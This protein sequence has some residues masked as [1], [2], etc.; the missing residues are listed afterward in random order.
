MIAIGLEIIFSP[1]IIYVRPKTA[2]IIFTYTTLIGL[3]SALQLYS[4]YKYL[5]QNIASFVFFKDFI[6]DEL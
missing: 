5:T 2:A 1:Y 3:V 6:L 4:T